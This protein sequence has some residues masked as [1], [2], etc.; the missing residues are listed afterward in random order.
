MPATN[1]EKPLAKQVSELNSNLANKVQSGGSLT[2][3]SHITSIAMEWNDT[4]G[5]HMKVWDG[6][7]NL[8]RIKVDANS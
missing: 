8:R 5:W 2:S 6:A 4:L 7:G 1:F 3:D